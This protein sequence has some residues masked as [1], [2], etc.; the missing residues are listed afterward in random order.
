MKVAVVGA[1]IMGASTAYALSLRGH[2]TVVFEQ[3]ERGHARGSS[4]GSS[5]IVRKAYPD[6]FYSKIMLDAYPLW[7]ELQAR[8]KRPI[9]HE[10]GLLYFGPETSENMRSQARGLNDLG[11]EHAV[12]HE[13]SSIGIGLQIPEGS[14]GLYSKDGG[15]VH[16]ENAV[17]ALLEG[18]EAQGAMVVRE[19]VRSL[20]ELAHF[21]RIVLC[22][23]AWI[24]RFI[25]L[26]VNITL[27]T[28]AYFEGEFE[29]PVWI[30]DGPNNFYGF[31]SEPG[32]TDF[33]VGVHR[34][35]RE[36][37]P[38]DSL[39]EPSEEYID[40]MK[41]ACVRLGLSDRPRLTRTVTCL[42]TNTACEDFLIGKIDTRTVFASPCSGHGFKFGPWM[43]RL[44]ADILEEK[45]QPEQY[46]RW[47]YSAAG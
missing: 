7:H 35:D 28:L 43:G 31:P 25:N 17:L 6:P 20:T 16:A 10:T 32:A 45:V 40:L 14:I 38:D 23:G 15:W 1:G 13:V 24:Q 39:R 12:I 22:C 8:S 27:Q 47:A 41:H 37:E 44:L 4:H 30:E 34:P 21:D 36:I 46:P 3:F 2:E 19:Q 33:K 11:I 9:L 42:Y 5:R 29:G 26:P 18:A